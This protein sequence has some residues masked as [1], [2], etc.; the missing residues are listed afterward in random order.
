MYCQISNGSTIEID[1]LTLKNLR[2][3][4]ESGGQVQVLGKLLFEENIGTSDILSIYCSGGESII[5]ITGEMSFKDCQNAGALRV[6]IVNNGIAILNKLTFQNCVHE[7]WQSK[8]GGMYASITTGGQ[9]TLTQSALF[10]NCSSLSNGAGLG[11]GMYIYVGNS[12]CLVQIIGEMT[13]ENC[14]S[15]G[16]GGGLFCSSLGQV[17]LNKMTFINCSGSTG[18]GM[19]LAGTAILQGEVTFTDCNSTQIGSGGGGG[20]Y[21]TPDHGRLLIITGKLTFERCSSMF[22]GG[23]LYI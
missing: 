20:L 14:S 16:Q 3:N 9:L 1:K 21:L 12:N 15:L 22:Y 8:G 7:Q 2:F 11:G 4:V 10:K 23:G 19:S 13:F 6:D 17:Y 18:G 5:E